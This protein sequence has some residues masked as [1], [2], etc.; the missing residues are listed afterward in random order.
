[1]QEQ[2]AAVIATAQAHH[3]RLVESRAIE[4]WVALA[5]TNE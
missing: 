3:L 1:L 4:D 2:A 5:F